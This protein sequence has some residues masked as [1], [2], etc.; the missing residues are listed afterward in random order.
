MTDEQTPAL[1]D[2]KPDP[3]RVATQQ[4]F[5]RELTLT[6]LRAGR[7]IREVARL[8][9]LPTSTVG[10]YFSGR[11][12]PP[13]SQPGLLPAVLRAC[14][15]T[16]PDRIGAWAS[17]LSRARRAPG[18]RRP[19]ARPP[20]LGLASFQAADAPWFF[21]RA[22]VT[23]RLVTQAA[24]RGGAVPSDDQGQTDAHGKR[25]AQSQTDAQGKADGPGPEQ[26]TGPRPGTDGLPLAV[27]GASGSGKSSLLRAGLV[28]RLTAGGRAAVLFTPS[29]QPL[30]E[31]AAQLAGLTAMTAAQIE[32]ALRR[33]PGSAA[34]LGLDDAAGRPLIVVDQFEAV[35]TRCPDQDQRRDF[36]TAV[37]A[38]AGPAVVVL[39]LRA[40]FYDRALRYPQLA[41]A[42][43]ERQTVLGPMSAAQLR[44]AIV[45]PARL[46]GLEVDDGLV[47]VLLRD[48][49]PRTAGHGQA[50]AAHEPGALPLLSHALLATWEHSSGSR[51]TVTDYQAGGGISQAI[52]RTAESVYASL[53]GPQQGTARQ[54]F[55]RLVHAASD[56]PQTRSVVRLSE[57]DEWPRPDNPAAPV[58]ARFVDE[59]L[60]TTDAGTAQ[61]THEALLTAWPRLRAW[62]DADRD[63]MRVRQRVGEAAQAW[64][65]ADRDNAALL[66]GSR[67]ADAAD[68][69]GQPGNEQTLD[70]L[71]RDFLDRS[72][73]QDRARMLAERS[74][75][76]RL[77][78]LVAAL[79]A[80]VLLTCGL[81]VYAFMLRM[82][83]DRAT[84]SAMAA[85]NDADSRELAVE[86]SQV[87]GQ[88]VTLAAQLSLA[89]FQIAPTTEARA[90]LLE[91]SGTPAAARLID[92]PGIAQAAALSPDRRVLAVAA[93]DG[94]LRLWHTSDR[95]RLTPLGPAL[96]PRGGSALYTA[97][98]ST[99]G[100]LLA[101]AGAG[102]QVS[103]WN[104]RD[105]GRPVPLGSLR[106]PASTVYAVAFSP[107]ARLLAVGGADDRVRLWHLAAGLPASPAATLTGPA[108]YV[109]S[110]AFSPD[111]RWLAAGSADHTVRLWDVAD[112]AHP[113]RGPAALTG[114][115]G[116]VYSVAFSQDGTLLAAGGK[117]DKVWLW[118]VARPGR[119]ARDGA[120]LTAPSDWVNA[121]A[122]SPDSRSL[123][124]ASSDGNVY[125]WD[126]PSRRLTA[127]LPHPQPATALAW[128][129][130]GA[131]ITADADGMARIWALPTPVLL[132]RQP[133][134]S[135]AFAG[136]G[137]M[138]A[139][140][141]KQGLEMW[142]RQSRS[143]LAEV[144]LPAADMGVIT[145][146]AAPGGT[147][148]ATGYGNGLL[149]LWRASMPPV[150]VSA[151]IR[152]VAASSSTDE[153][154][155]A[156]FSPDG[157]TLA[158]GG[159]DG[160]LRLW[161]VTDP[162]PPK[163]LAMARDSDTYVNSVAFSPDGRI[164][165]AASADNLTRLWRIN[166]P[167]RL[168]PEGRPLAGPASYALSVAFSPDGTTLAVGSADKTIRLWDVADPARPTLIGKPLRGPASYVYS[169]AFSPDGAT[170]AAG[171]TDGTVWLWNIRAP[172]RPA[173][174]ATLTGPD[175]QVFSV[176]FA[177]GGQVLTAGS[178]DGT[179]RMW[180]TS[181]RADAR[182]VCAYAGQPL[183]RFEWRTYV[184]G[185]SYHPPCPAGR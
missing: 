93:A 121:V 48:L 78:R 17:A 159:D 140:G 123:A 26:E 144:P 27:V 178:A 150:P 60:I 83:A 30:A 107:R 134:Y 74:G 82:A 95:A 106:G 136:A 80:L 158:T 160:M 76:R 16:D 11:H 15:E 118:N 49:A 148:L 131:L 142:D 90:S 108:G 125:I 139:V 117:D 165:A 183:T 67:L 166:G 135:L 120:P 21:G 69:A 46:A 79:T 112:P 64:A 109:Q 39:A 172:A 66:R 34:R 32:A 23:E 2:D 114:P 36:I 176:A 115:G 168:T 92:S 43:Q 25:H 179:V 101:A 138:L 71:A 154:E 126:L 19:G 24:G 73:E 6:R 128:S 98:F 146:A 55:L 14:G 20:Y 5:G 13:P 7:T 145:V 177:P 103:L 141:T 28:P 105:P 152:A 41:R 133:V 33:D 84:V 22:E 127:T 96:R 157:R 50:G 174:L 44:S 37:C 113:R 182:S 51:L 53:T 61:L 122:F 91:T 116:V 18:R 167:A 63:N 9:G 155:S 86:A 143:E 81:T 181:P 40:D 31:L 156:V 99:D 153:V 184:P 151:P 147:L 164:L 149:Q 129:G 52:A 85:R 42:L 54:L 12:L 3:G 87:R 119:P 29:A 62:I 56:M 77:H 8:S 132:A 38:L 75:T 163:L 185:L 94:S 173:L 59:R 161:S 89:A 1:S 58:L 111:G 170:L 10:D 171:V 110:V 4:D 57:L 102:G 97:A 100:S 162:G 130:S 175:A 65:E 35:F 45:E 47:E 180:D 68:W 169:V 70:G 104:V 88:N 124:A 72:A 137:R